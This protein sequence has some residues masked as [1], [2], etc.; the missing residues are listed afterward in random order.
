MAP[1]PVPASR[2]EAAMPS[3]MRVY[4]QDR[5]GDALADVTGSHDPL[6]R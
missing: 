6:W 3:A 2:R 5:P 4:R 1:T